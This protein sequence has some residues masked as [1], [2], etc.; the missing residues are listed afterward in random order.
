MRCKLA[1]KGGFGDGVA[2]ASPMIKSAKRWKREKSAVGIAYLSLV[3]SLS[4]LY[5]NFYL[6]IGKIIS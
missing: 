4:V 5:S 3:E 1:K 2:A 6:I